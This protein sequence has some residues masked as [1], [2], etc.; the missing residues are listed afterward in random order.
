MGADLEGFG[1]EALC[2]GV[3]GHFEGLDTVGGGEADG[4]GFAERTEE[5]WE[6]HA[7]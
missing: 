2:G 6:E 4:G 7:R 3:G 1:L 5:T